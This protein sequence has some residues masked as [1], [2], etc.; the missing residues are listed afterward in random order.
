MEGFGGWSGNVIRMT[1]KEDDLSNFV[2]D[3]LEDV[4]LRVLLGL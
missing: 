3:G 4:K 2:L 1:G